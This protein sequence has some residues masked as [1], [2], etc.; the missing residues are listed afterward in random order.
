[1]QVLY[2]TSRRACQGTLQDPNTGGWDLSSL[3]EKVAEAAESEDSSAF[4]ECL[5]LA[6]PNLNL[7]CLALSAP[8]LN[9]LATG[10]I[11]SRQQLA[12]GVP[13]GCSGGAQRSYG[14]HLHPIRLRF[15]GK[16]LF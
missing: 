8:N 15:H 4:L 5:A 9:G 13:W 16:P 2:D 6:A 10:R 7:E 12:G 14:D 11:G 1:M 3:V